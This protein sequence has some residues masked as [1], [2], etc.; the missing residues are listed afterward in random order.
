MQLPKQSQPLEENERWTVQQAAN[1]LGGVSVGRVYDL[2]ERGVLTPY[3]LQEGQIVPRPEEL[4]LGREVF[5]RKSEVIAYGNQRS[6][7][8][9]PPGAKNKK[10]KN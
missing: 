4:K 3:I 10:R 9:R 1:A 8:G 5:L 7:R 2:I 6:K